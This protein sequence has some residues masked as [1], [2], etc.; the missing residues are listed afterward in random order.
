MTTMDSLNKLNL[1]MLLNNMTT[2]QMVQMPQ[3]QQQQQMLQPQLKLPGGL[4]SQNILSALGMQQP[5]QAGGI[6]GSQLLPGGDAAPA[7]VSGNPISALGQQQQQFFNLRQAAPHFHQQATALGKRPRDDPSAT[8]WMP[9]PQAP[10]AAPDASHGGHGGAD[11]DKSSG[12]GRRRTVHQLEV[13]ESV[14]KLCPNP[15]EARR[16]Q[17]GQM[18]KMEERQVVIWFQNKRQRVRAKMKEQENSTL[19]KQ[20]SAL[21]SELQ[22]EKAR[23]RTLEQENALLKSWM[24]DKVKKMEELR[25]ASSKLL[26]E[27]YKKKGNPDG[28]WKKA[29]PSKLAEHL[30]LPSNN[31][32]GEQKPTAVNSDEAAPSPEAAPAAAATTTRTPAAGNASAGE[33]AASGEVQVEE[34]CSPTTPLKLEDAETHPAPAPGPASA[35]AP[36]NSAGVDPPSSCKGEEGS[37]KAAMA[38]AQEEAPAMKV[39]PVPEPEQPKE[40]ATTN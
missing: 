30:N 15:T 31:E 39:E 7:T 28:S 36:V 38:Q 16:K 5:G 8:A 35:P 6:L 13:L 18:L 40:E 27:Y 20:H 2:Q 17:L 37:G 32:E 33:E 24:D 25:Q 12:S 22:R 4:D 34:K 9:H 11:A 19:R 23:E 10:L 14:F 29:L 1:G 26:V 3:Q 21:K